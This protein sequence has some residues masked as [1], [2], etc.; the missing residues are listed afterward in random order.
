MKNIRQYLYLMLCFLITASVGYCLQAL[1]DQPASAQTG[2]KSFGLDYFMPAQSFSEVENARALLHALAA[3]SLQE[4]RHRRIAAGQ[5]DS[6]MAD[7]DLRREQEVDRLI[8]DFRSAIH[9]FSGTGHEWL[10]VQDL[11][12]LLKNEGRHADW[13]TVYVHAL[14]QNPTHEMIERLALDAV[15]MAEHTSRN[16]EVLEAIALSRA[17][18]DAFARNSPRLR[19]A[20]RLYVARNQDRDRSHSTD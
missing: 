3:R 17:I 14:Y 15:R 20:D 4:L 7:K 19:S 16:E 8:A 18:P 6:M 13:V 2:E 11:L 1:R 10:F 9:E 5:P 12:W